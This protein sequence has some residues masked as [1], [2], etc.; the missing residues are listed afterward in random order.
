MRRWP[1]AP[2]ILGRPP[3]RPLHPGAC[4]GDQRGDGRAAPQTATC[5]RTRPLPRRRSRPSISGYRGGAARRLAD[6]LAANTRARIRASR[7][8]LGTR[9]QRG[10]PSAIST[11]MSATARPPEPDIRPEEVLIETV[12]R[13]LAGARH[14]AV[15]ANSPIP[16]AA[17]FLEQ[18]LTGGM[19]LVSLQQSPSTIFFTDGGRELFDAAGQGR[20]DVFF[21]SG[22]ADRRAGNIILVAIGDYARP[23]ARFPGSVGS[24]VSVLHGAA[25]HSFPHRAF[26][27]HARRQSRFRERA[28]HEP[29]G[30]VPPRRP[31]GAGDT[32]LPFRL[33]SESAAFAWRASTPVTPSRKCATHRL[34]LRCAGP[35]GR[36]RRCRMPA[37]LAHL[38]GMSRA[39]S[40][41]SIPIRRCGVWDRGE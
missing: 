13:L 37:A 7:R 24:A 2:A 15:G 18:H 1:T 10:I 4:G 34:R 39:N 11:A 3:P 17:A 29:A 27:P 20:I 21:L 36:P 31:G 19:P 12:L 35:G 16:A 9:R 8:I 41:G 40:R 22:A 5:S 32:A 26:A 28:R 25:D 38:R 14:V 30:R 6:A 23:N 33:R